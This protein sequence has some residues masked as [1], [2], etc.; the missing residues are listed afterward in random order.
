[1]CF[2]FFACESEA[3]KNEE[4]AVA[5]NAE[6]ASVPCEIFV[7]D[8]APSL[9]SMRSLVSA[10]DRRNRKPSIFCVFVVFVFV[11]VFVF[12]SVV[13]RSLFNLFDFCD[14][15]DEEKLDQNDGI[16]KRS[17]RAQT[18]NNRRGRYYY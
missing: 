3:V 17:R 4:N 10:K 8:D 2:L 6:S 9:S 18:N 1:L 12:F 15:D 7:D 14:D 11:F 16:K 13:G 5:T